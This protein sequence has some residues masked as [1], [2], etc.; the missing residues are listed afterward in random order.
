MNPA[1]RLLGKLNF[2]TSDSSE[3]TFFDGKYTEAVLGYAFRPVRHDRLNTLVKYTFFNNVPTTDQ[4]TQSNSAAEYIQKSHVAAV[5][6]N[7][8]LSATWSIGGKY[9]H[10]IGKI[11]LDRENP[12][13]FDN[14]ANLYVFRTDWRF[15]EKWEFL[16]EGR[17][18]EMA[19]LD[20]RRAGVLVALSRYVGEHFKVGTGYNFTDFSDDL[21]DL[22]YDH[23]GV[24]LNLTG[25]F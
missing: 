7:Y 23:Q 15:R 22:N 18:L 24:F 12:E 20:E 10:R 2:S 13:F 11:S 14:T 8:D 19:D 16:L 17:M 3:G 1:S 5:D 9:A 21:T 25:A 4:V 6:L